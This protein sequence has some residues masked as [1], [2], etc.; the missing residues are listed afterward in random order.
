MLMQQTYLSVV[1]DE[2]KLVLAQETPNNCG[3][4][5]GQKRENVIACI[6]IIF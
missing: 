3:A 2:F 1:S 4:L 6:L 5:K